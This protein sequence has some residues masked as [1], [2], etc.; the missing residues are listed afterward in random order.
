MRRGVTL[1]EIS[2][3]CL[4]QLAPDRA[5]AIAEARLTDEAPIVRRQAALIT[6]RRAVG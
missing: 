6:T 3:V 2:L 4:A 1:V 5:A